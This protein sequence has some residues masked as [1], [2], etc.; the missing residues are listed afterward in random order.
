M[1]SWSSDLTLIYQGFQA[2]NSKKFKLEISNSNFGG[3]NLWSN[4]FEFRLRK[5]V[6]RLMPAA[7]LNLL[8]EKV[9]NSPSIFSEF[10]F[11][12]SVLLCSFL[13]LWSRF[14]NSPLQSLVNQYFSQIKSP[15]GWC[16]VKFREFEGKIRW[17]WF[18]PFNEIT[19]FTLTLFEKVSR[20]QN[21][22][23]KLQESA[24]FSR[25]NWVL[26]PA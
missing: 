5:P 23:K 1:I 17:Q 3:S 4:F 22:E 11:P 8:P 18:C 16:V 2:R 24:L 6:I 12:N 13:G 19:E 10:F 9:S 7:G 20:T 25:A 14:I 21:S 15:W 26:Q